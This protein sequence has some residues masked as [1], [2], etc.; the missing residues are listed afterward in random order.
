MEENPLKQKIN[1]HS[2]PKW[3]L[4]L[5]GVRLLDDFV[6]HLRRLL[7]EGTFHHSA[8][9]EICPF[10]EYRYACQQ[11]GRRMAHLLQV[12]GGDA[13]YSGERNREQWNLLQ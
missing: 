12:K 2:E 3:G 10:C 1:D 11:D 8:D 13:I 5:N 4:D 9:E 7:A 6:E